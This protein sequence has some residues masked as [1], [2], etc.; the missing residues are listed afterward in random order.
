MNN[1]MLGLS[2]YIIFHS[3]KSNIKFLVQAIIAAILTSEV[4]IW[5]FSSCALNSNPFIILCMKL[6]QS[7]ARRKSMAAR[8]STVAIFLQLFDPVRLD[9]KL[10]RIKWYQDLQRFD[11]QC[12]LQAFHIS[13]VLL[14]S[15]VEVVKLTRYFCLGFLIIIS[16]CANSGSGRKLLSII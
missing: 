3:E 2:H 4:K 12:K 9:S 11:L 5:Q 14:D 10:E 16:D 1:G 7:K 15:R 8:L 13:S 6:F